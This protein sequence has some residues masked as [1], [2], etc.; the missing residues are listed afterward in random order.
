MLTILRSVGAAGCPRC[1][2]QVAP[3]DLEDV[4]LVE[5]RLIDPHLEGYVRYA[6]GGQVAVCQA[7]SDQLDALAGELDAYRRRLLRT[8][9][10]PRA[11]RAAPREDQCLS[12]PFEALRDTALPTVLGQAI[13]HARQ[14]ATA[15]LIVSATGAWR[16][17]DVP[18]G[19][20]DTPRTEGS[21]VVVPIPVAPSATALAD[22]DLVGLSIEAVYHHCVGTKAE[23][24]AL[25][26]LLAARFYRALYGQEEDEGE[27]VPE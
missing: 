16:V 5:L 26:R 17:E 8:W 19:Q 22:E 1:G 23:A 10:T 6:A 9:P 20:A 24:A 4:S 2:R 12:R 11:H 21:P 3:E 27:E 25:E 18:V 14:G 15:Y 7:C 13:W